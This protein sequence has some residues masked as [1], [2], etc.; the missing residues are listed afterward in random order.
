MRPSD[1]APRESI[2]GWA[3][4]TSRRGECRPPRPHSHTG[5][6]NW[7]VRGVGMSPAL[8]LTR[9]SSSSSHRFRH[10]TTALCVCV[11]VCVCVCARAN[12]TAL[13][14]GWGGGGGGVA[15]PCRQHFLVLLFPTWFNQQPTSARTRWLTLLR[16]F[17]LLRR[18][19]RT[20]TRG[21][22]VKRLGEG[23]GRGWCRADP[24]EV[25]ARG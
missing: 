19:R 5:R 18:E 11:C 8:Q 16:L 17:F 1:S 15:R 20:D 9:V 3:P 12:W 13:L 23:G 21:E 7:V 24:V 6:A 4:A 25:N 2:R 22:G 10:H 14:I